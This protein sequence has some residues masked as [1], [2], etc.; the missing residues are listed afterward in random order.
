MTHA[1]LLQLSLDAKSYDEIFLFDNDSV[2]PVREADVEGLA[3]RVTILEREGRGVIH[4][5][6]NEGWNIAAVKAAGEPFNIAF[7]NNDIR[8]ESEFLASLSRALRSGPDIGAVYPNFDDR[9]QARGILQSTEGIAPDGGM[10][11]FAFMLRGEIGIR[12]DEAFRWWYGEQDLEIRVRRAGYRVCCVTDV[13]IR[14][15]EPYRSTAENPD[16][17]YLA[18]RDREYFEQKWAA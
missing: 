3:P 18:A 10:S 4:K 13:R 12:F 9:P 16:L 15:L 1:L 2:V 6:W 17:A 8:V 11:G 14:H 5:N 7:L